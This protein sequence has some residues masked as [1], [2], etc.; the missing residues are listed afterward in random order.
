MNIIPLREEL[1]TYFCHLLPK[2]VII[3]YD[4]KDIDNLIKN[5]LKKTEEMLKSKNPR[6]IWETT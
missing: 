5:H 1:I 6:E 3:T 4:E 2:G